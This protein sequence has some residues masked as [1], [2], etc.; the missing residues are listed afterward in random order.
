MWRLAAVVRKNVSE[1]RIASI[2]SVKF[3]GEVEKR[4]AVARK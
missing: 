4:L 2:I 3:I 1:E